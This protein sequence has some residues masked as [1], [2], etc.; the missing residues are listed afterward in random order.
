M[1]FTLKHKNVSNQTIFNDLTDFMCNVFNTLHIYMRS[2]GY[3]EDFLMMIE[4]WMEAY[5]ELSNGKII[6]YDVVCDSRNN[7]PED[8]ENGKINFTI[9]YRLKNCLNTTE[10]N[11]VLEL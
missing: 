1:K 7:R 8:M 10:L 9:K 5:I 2:P 11:Y 4:D 6:Q 3:R